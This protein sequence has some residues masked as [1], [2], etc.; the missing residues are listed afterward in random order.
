MKKLFILALA[1][2]LCA[3]VGCYDSTPYDRDEMDAEYE[4][5]HEAGYSDG[6]QDGYL[7]GF[8]AG[9]LSILEATEQPAW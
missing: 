1:L 5:G 4:R 9:Q 3:F 6:Y 7:E 2:L 8:E